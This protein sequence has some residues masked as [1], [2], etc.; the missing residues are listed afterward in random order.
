MT[1]FKS[2]DV[3]FTLWIARV[4]AAFAG[5][6][7]FVAAPH[8]PDPCGTKTRNPVAGSDLRSRPR[9]EKRSHW[10]KRHTLAHAHTQDA[11]THDL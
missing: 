4:G 5:S 11:E 3:M 6:T 2:M 10:S 7:D 8:S 9:S 1:C